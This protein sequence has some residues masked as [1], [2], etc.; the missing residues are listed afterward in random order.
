MRGLDGRKVKDNINALQ[1]IKYLL[2]ICHRDQANFRA[3][4]FN[5]VSVFGFGRG[6]GLGEHG[7][8]IA[9]SKAM[10]GKS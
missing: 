5:Q 3:L 2:S 8:R 10:E 7:H 9:I 6:V 1:G 4:S